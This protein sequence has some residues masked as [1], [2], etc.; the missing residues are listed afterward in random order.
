MP[1]KFVVLKGEIDANKFDGAFKI[2]ELILKQ[3]YSRSKTADEMS[4]M[5]FVIPALS[6]L[7]LDHVLALVMRCD[8]STLHTQFV[9]T[10]WPDSRRW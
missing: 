3:R 6:A 8:H 2:A 7:F 4:H 5:V 10:Y 1:R 9:A